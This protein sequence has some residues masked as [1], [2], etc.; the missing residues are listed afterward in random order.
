[1]ETIVPFPLAGV[2]RAVRS[3]AQW[4]RITRKL[5][6]I[7]TLLVLIETHIFNK[8]KM[9]VSKISI[10]FNETN[11]IKEELSYSLSELLLYSESLGFITLVEVFALA[12]DVSEGGASKRART[13]EGSDPLDFFGSSLKEE[14]TESDVN[15]SLRI[16]SRLVDSSDN[17]LV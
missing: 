5:A 17:F 12:T 6:K 9:K 2:T 14:I 16:K 10:K 7:I 3:S 1:L 13:A 4:A 15:I 11:V 8:I